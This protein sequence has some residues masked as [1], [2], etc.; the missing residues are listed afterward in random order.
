MAVF[1]CA[2]MVE[3]CLANQDAGWKHFV[4]DYLPF[5]ALL[6]DRHYPQ[7]ITSREDL[8]REVLLR[9]RDEEREFFREYRGHS[10]REFLAHLRGLAL[11]VLEEAEPAVPAPEILLPWES[12]E[13]SFSGL[14]ALERQVVWLFL[15][16][17][18]AEDAPLLLRADRTSVTAMLGRAQEQLR[19]ALDHWSADLLEQN[20]HLLAAE[21]RRR[22]TK[23]CPDP[24][25]WLRL[26]DGQ[27]TWRDRQDLE[28]HLV[29]CWF[30][31]DRLCRFREVMR[32]S[33]LVQPLTEI[34]AQPF[35]KT[36]GLGFA[37][38]S[39]WKRLLGV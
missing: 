35:A 32:L 33:R 38:P 27:I 2:E 25:A 28:R 39:R 19:G 8:L 20:R 36:I 10:E 37:P 5:A 16:C 21:V 23:E 22:E 13:R 30:C 12:F 24:R 9:A 26:L 1:T 18:R 31:V 6:L 34:E 3:A 7:L 4:T 29:V 11:R 17:P 15:L 14:T